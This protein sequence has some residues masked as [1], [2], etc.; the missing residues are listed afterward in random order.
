MFLH[1]VEVH[2]LGEYR[3]KLKFNNGNETEVDLINELYGEVFEP[4]KNPE[5]FRQVFINPETN[6]IEWPNGA[7]FSPEF[8]YESGFE[9][10]PTF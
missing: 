5:F 9:R 8:L 4:L 2:Y 1:I 6:T 10:I 3:L 7:D